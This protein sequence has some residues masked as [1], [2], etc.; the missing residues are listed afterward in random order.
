M[1]RVSDVLSSVA[2]ESDA[3]AISRSINGI[4]PLATCVPLIEIFLPAF[5]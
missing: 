1:R 2:D 5:R 3:H 4:D